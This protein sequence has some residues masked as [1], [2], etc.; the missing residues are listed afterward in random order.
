MYNI[1]AR[2][3]VTDTQLVQINERQIT[4]SQHQQNFMSLNTHNRVRAKTYSP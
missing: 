3:N 1:A 2:M 4:K